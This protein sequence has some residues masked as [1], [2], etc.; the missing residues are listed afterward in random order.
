LAIGRTDYA[1]TAVKSAKLPRMVGVLG[2]IGGKGVPFGGGRHSA[3]IHKARRRLLSAYNSYLTIISRL[4]YS[5]DD[6]KVAIK[7]AWP[8]LTLI[9]KYIRNLEAD[10]VNILQRDERE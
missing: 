6:V 2:A 5:E 4:G 8:C 3:A 7:L 10:E 9:H 1:P